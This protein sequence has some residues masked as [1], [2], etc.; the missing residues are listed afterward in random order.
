MARRR[1]WPRGPHRA[2]GR[3]DRLHV[4]ARDGFDLDLGGG[5]DISYTDPIGTSP[6][7]VKPVA[8]EVARELGRLPDDAPVAV[9]EFAP[10]NALAAFV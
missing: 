9:N 8:N 1:R 7:Y 2:G 4:A 6:L 5:V 3:L 10:E